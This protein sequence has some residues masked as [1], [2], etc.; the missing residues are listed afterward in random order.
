MRFAIA[1]AVLLCGF[2][3]A[4]PLWVELGPQNGAH[5]LSVPS[6]GDGKKRA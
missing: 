2:A 3:W 5:G 6:E 4:E 1:L